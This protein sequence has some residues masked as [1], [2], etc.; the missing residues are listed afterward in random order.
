MQPDDLVE[1]ST[2][3]LVNFA[4]NRDDD[5]HQRWAA[6]RALQD[7][8]TREVFEAARELCA[9]V[10]PH[11]RCLGVDILAQGQSWVKTFH[12]EAVTLLLQVLEREDEPR[13][14]SS[15]GMALDH[16]HDRRA[17]EPLAALRNHPDAGVRYSVVHGLLRHQDDQAVQ[18]LIEL[19]D[20]EASDVRDW[21]TFGLCV[22]LDIDTPAL[23][24][25]L[26]RRLADADPDTRGEAMVG[27]ARRHDNRVVP[28][29]V[30]ALQAGWDGS[31]VREA[32]E[33][34]RHPEV[35]NALSRSKD[36]LGEQARA[37]ADALLR[38]SH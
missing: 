10:E 35:L 21:A 22:L 13:V 5:D 8:G 4:L 28:A 19:S 30:E 18:A 38:V 11:E 1:Q 33:E 6:I 12:D 26:V 23:R 15:I 16:R 20:D 31:L 34:F 2:A 36:Q 37:W 7:R 17:V 14:L 24:E 29:L 27:L 9:G 3:W 25:A 32:V